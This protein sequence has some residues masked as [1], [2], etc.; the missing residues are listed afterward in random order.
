M[1]TVQTP[2]ER[3]LTPAE[4]AALVY[5][6]P[7]TV[8]RWATAGKIPF[9]RTLGGHRRFRRSDVQALLSTQHAQGQDPGD[10][11]SPFRSQGDPDLGHATPTGELSRAA[12]DAVVAGAI[13]IALEGH[14][15]TAEEAV[16][17][18]AASV[19]AAAQTVAAA[20]A[21]ARRARA[22]VAAEAA[23][24]VA[25]EATGAAAAVRSHATAQAAYLAETAAQAKRLV[26]ASTG[27][28]RTTSEAVLMAATVQAAADAASSDTELAV[29]RVAQAVADAAAHVALMVA[30]FDLSVERETSAAAEALHDLTVEMARHVTRR[31]H[32]VTRRASSL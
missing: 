2:H 16:L 29:E 19:A 7:K 11:A 21:K 12:A 18:T 10:I 15:E 9:T 27:P 13:A 25:T 30:A 23:K 22:C 6:D 24:L 5:V 3:L 20:A 32:A 17:E 1:P 28:A 8:S 14:A 26:L 31:N 4:V